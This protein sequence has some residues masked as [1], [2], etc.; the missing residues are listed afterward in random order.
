MK[1]YVAWYDNGEAYEDNFQEIEAIF[2]S[3]ENAVKFIE[4]RD[5]RLEQP[6][7][8]WRNYD[9]WSDS[10]LVEQYPDEYFD[11]SYFTIREFEL[12]KIPDYSD[13]GK[14]E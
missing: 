3:Y 10:H 8:K 11:V 1:V 12:D 9:L 13:F 14:E 4:D 7:P 6:R 5:Y 2:S